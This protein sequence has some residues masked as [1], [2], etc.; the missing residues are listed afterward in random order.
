MKATLQKNAGPDTKTP[1]PE[2]RGGGE[3][4]LLLPR[5]FGELPFFL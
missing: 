3:K 2:I 1:L 4:V 5:N